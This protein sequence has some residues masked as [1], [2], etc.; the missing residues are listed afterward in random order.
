MRNSQQNSRSGAS[1]A[2]TVSPNT[3]G[4]DYSQNTKSR[5]PGSTGTAPGGA[6]PESQETTEHT[7]GGTSS[8]RPRRIDNQ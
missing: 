2:S 4:D 8:D 1:Q 7:A 6:K 3:E 5:R